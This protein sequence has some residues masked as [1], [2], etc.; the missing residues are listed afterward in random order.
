MDIKINDGS[1]ICATCKYWNN[2]T[3]WDT[4]G[5]GTCYY[6]SERDNNKIPMKWYLNCV[7]QSPCASLATHGTFGCIYHKFGKFGE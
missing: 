4:K 5:F 1:A 7:K 2:N 6:R 3:T